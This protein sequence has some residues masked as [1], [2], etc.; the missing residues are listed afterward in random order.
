MKNKEL[1]SY[2]ANQLNLDGEKELIAKIAILFDI[3]IDKLL[4]IPETSTQS[5]I[6]SHFKTFMLSLNDFEDEIE[7]IER[8]SIFENLYALGV[9]V[10]LD[11]KTEYAEDWRG[12]W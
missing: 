6:L 2:Q 5:T 11:P 3:L 12:D 8:E 7:T 1:Q 4:H 9:I 10:G